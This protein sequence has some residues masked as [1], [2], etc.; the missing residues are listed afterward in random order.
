MPWSQGN[1]K[2]RLYRGSLDYRKS[3][4]I[5][6]SI[7]KTKNNNK[8]TKMNPNHPPQKTTKKKQQ[9]NITPNNPFPK[10]NENQKKLQKTH[11]KTQQKTKTT[12]TQQ[13]KHK[14]TLDNF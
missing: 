13:N 1:W 12:K 8:Q 4:E 5:K 11:E 3:F 10:I 6:Q 14:Q 9:K 7:T 2:C